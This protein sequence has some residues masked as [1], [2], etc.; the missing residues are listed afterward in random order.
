MRSTRQAGI[1]GQGSACKRRLISS[2]ISDFAYIIDYI[3]SSLVINVWNLVELPT[4]FFFDWKTE[5]FHSLLDPSL[6]L[7]IN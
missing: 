3:P 7:Q 4:S 5:I 2:I 6:L 1:Y